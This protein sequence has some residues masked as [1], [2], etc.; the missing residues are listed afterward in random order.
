M[1]FVRTW[2][3]LGSTWLVPEMG[4]V[5]IIFLTKK[6]CK[7]GESQGNLTFK[8]FSAHNDCKRF[9]PR[10]S[11]GWVETGLPGTENISRLQR[12]PEKTHACASCFV[13][14]SVLEKVLWLQSTGVSFCRLFLTLHVE[15]LLLRW[16]PHPHPLLRSTFFS[17]YC[18]GR[19]I[20]SSKI[21]EVLLLTLG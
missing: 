13:P 1:I 20:H 5:S 12:I 7:R 19:S 8:N 10:F 2:T 14:F 21:S 6:N 16:T 4:H 3:S 11:Q 9:S 17:Q 15:A 18:D